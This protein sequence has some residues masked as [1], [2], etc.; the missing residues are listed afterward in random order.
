MKHKIRQ[1]RVIAAIYLNNKLLR[2]TLVIVL[3]IHSHQA[4]LNQKFN[5]LGAAVVKLAKLI[6][7]QLQILLIKQITSKGKV[8]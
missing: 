6:P 4:P 1:V 8:V 2:K 7:Q 5:L 3:K